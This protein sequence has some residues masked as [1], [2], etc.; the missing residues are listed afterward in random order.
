MYLFPSPC[1]GLSA[2]TRTRNSFILV[3]IRVCMFI[4]IYVHMWASKYL[5]PHTHI[6]ICIYIYT[7]TS[8]Y[9]CAQEYDTFSTEDACTTNS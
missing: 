1:T 9:L 8:L 2:P 7:Y 6:C 3:F 4:S 5:F